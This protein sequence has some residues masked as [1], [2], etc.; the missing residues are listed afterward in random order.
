MITYP[1]LS[2]FIPS[3]IS[4]QGYKIGPVS[5][6]VCLLVFKSLLGENTDKKHEKGVNTQTFSLQ[7]T[8]GSK[9]PNSFAKGKYCLVISSC[10][11]YNSS[12]ELTVTW[13][14]LAWSIKDNGNMI[15]WLSAACNV[16]IHS[17]LL[18][19][20]EFMKGFRLNTYE[21]SSHKAF[22]T[23]ID[24]VSQKNEK[25]VFIWTMRSKLSG[26]YLDVYGWSGYLRLKTILH[27]ILMHVTWVLAPYFP[28]SLTHGLLSNAET[29]GWNLSKIESVLWLCFHDCVVQNLISSL[30]WFF[31]P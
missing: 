14:C 4:G 7:Y 15:S 24:I 29:Q 12:W 31:I 30:K 22:A 3:S 11:Q 8:F 20:I 9:S 6:C 5:M 23:L 27:C 26:K 28:K 1:L 10:L 21:M 19:S 18:L 13:A 25:F 2:W 16:A 17:K